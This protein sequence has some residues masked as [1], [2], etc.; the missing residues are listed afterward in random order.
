MRLVVRAA[1]ALGVKVERVSVPNNLARFTYRGTNL[2][3]KGTVP[4]ANNLVASRISMSKHLT[5]IV[6]AKAGI[7]RFPKAEFVHTLTEANAAARQLKFPLVVK[8]VAGAHGFGITVNVRSRAEM[9]RAIAKAERINHSRHYDAGYVVEQLKTGSDYRFF[10]IDGRVWAVLERVPAS[11]TGDGSHSVAQLIKRWNAKPIVGGSDDFD[12]PLMAITVDD[13]VKRYLREQHAT[14]ATVPAKGQRL[15]LRRQAN[16]SLGGT[17]YDVTAQASP[18]LKRWA[19][20]AV[21]DVGLRVA[22]IDIMAKN[23][24]ARSP[25]AADAW[26]LEVNDAP[27]ID[28]HHYPYRGTAQPVAYGLVKS[29]FPSVKL[30]NGVLPRY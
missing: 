1:Q 20:R 12:K 15:W 8:P 17:S 6:L 13:D 16:I 11:V 22:G 24:R 5:K 25:E 9:A 2:F 3:V 27:G 4:P 28:I 7:R 21:A 29:M 10:V 23:I 19:A 26:I 30:P 18:Q 14:L